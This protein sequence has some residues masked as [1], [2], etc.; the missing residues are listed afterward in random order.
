MTMSK[1]GNTVSASSN[2]R[3]APVRV[4]LQRINANLAKAHPR[5]GVR[6][7]PADARLRNPGRN[8]TAPEKRRLASRPGRACACERGRPGAHWECEEG[9]QRRGKRK[10]TAWRS[11]SLNRRASDLGR[12]AV[13]I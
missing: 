9:W 3:P 13:L 11:P 6:S 1:T 12:E 7:S 8:A 10:M 4:K 5:D 2:G